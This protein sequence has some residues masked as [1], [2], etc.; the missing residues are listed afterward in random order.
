M[1][2]QDLFNKCKWRAKAKFRSLEMKKL[3][4]R[5]KE[6]I[7]SRDLAKVKNAKLI[8]ENEELRKQ[9]LELKNEIKKTDTE[10]SQA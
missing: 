5:N 4:K 9:N 1:K 3:K 10:Q 8:Q 6:L 7:K 2:L